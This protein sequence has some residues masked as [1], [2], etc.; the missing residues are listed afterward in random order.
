ML[1]IESPITIEWLYIS[2]SWGTGHAWKSV[3]DIICEVEKGSGRD[4][5]VIGFVAWE[6]NSDSDMAQSVE[7]VLA[8]EFGAFR[9]GKLYASNTSLW[10]A[11]RFVFL[12]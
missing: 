3:S 7:F 1:D 6:D 11:E 8:G 2:T 10:D 9:G 12:S 4:G 5:S